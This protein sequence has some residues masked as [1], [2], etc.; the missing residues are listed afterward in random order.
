MAYKD[1]VVNNWPGGLGDLGIPWAEFAVK[2]VRTEASFSSEGGGN[3]AVL[4][5]QV[6]WI[7]HEVAVQAL[8]GDNYRDPGTGLFVRK[9]PAPHPYYTNL[10]CSRVNVRPYKFIGK[11][12]LGTGVAADWRYAILTAVFTQPKWNRTLSD[13]ELLR[14]FGDPPEEWQ[15]FTI[16]HPQP[17][18]E[19]IS[20]PKDQL[21]WGETIGPV[22]AGGVLPDSI[23]RLLGK[24]DMT[25]TWCRVPG[26][27]LFASAGGVPGTGLPTNIVN[28]LGTVNNSPAI[29]GR[30]IGELLFKGAAIEP[31]ENAQT[32]GVLPDGQTNLLY[33]V[34]FFFSLFPTS[35]SG[36]EGSG[37]YHGHFL[38]F[39]NDAKL[40]LVVGATPNR[41][42]G[43][44]DGTGD[45]T[46]NWSLNQ[47]LFRQAD[48][49]QL[50][51]L[52]A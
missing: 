21:A 48:H 30:P 14:V 36:L 46:G 42:P 23:A 51:T 7:D 50:F 27:G 15:R 13:S 52:V 28:L 40:Y 47:W 44:P 39:A 26:R 38:S 11:T 5:L 20:R 19:T 4:P 37:A 1:L 33:N 34:R 3:Q 24:I 10:Y 43:P 18:V 35:T 17:M 16:W 9:L 25:L 8:V 6:R 22:V 45:G 2:S 32:A 29:F 41:G 49:T 31:V 12:D